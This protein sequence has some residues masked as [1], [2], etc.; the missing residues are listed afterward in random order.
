[1]AS[2]TGFLAKFQSVTFQLKGIALLVV[3]TLCFIGFKGLSGMNNAANSLEDLYSQGMQHTIRAGKI[4]DKL[5]DARSN[6]LLAQQHDPTSEVASLHDHPISVHFDEITTALASLHHIVD[7]EILVSD[8]SGEERALVN[9]MVDVLD[10]ITDEGFNPAIEYLKNNQFSDANLLLLKTINPEFKTLS[11]QAERFLALQT[12]EG[13]A[14]YNEAVDN[15]D[16][17]MWT[18]GGVIA[19]SVIVLFGLFAKIV[20]RMNNAITEIESTST[21]INKGDLTRRVNVSGDDEFA[22]IADSVNTLVANFQ[23]LVKD[24]QHSTGL[25]ANSASESAVVTNQTQRNV[26]DQQAQT[27]MIAA[28]IHEFTATVHE[29]ANNTSSAATASQEADNAASDGQKIVMRSIEM[30]EHLSRDLESTVDAM[31]Q[32]Q[33]H[34]EAIGSV[35]VTIQGISEQTNLLA[36]NAAIEAARAGEQGRGFAVVADEVRSLA[37]RTQSSTIEIQSTIQQLQEG[38]R[39]AMARMENGNTQAQETVQMAKDAGEAIKRILASVDEI[40]AMNTQIAT[41]AEQQSSVTEEINKNITTISSISDQTAAGAEQ[42]RIAADS[43]QK[44]SDEMKDK[45]QKY[46]I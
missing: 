10:V 42:S 1:M 19:L 41:A 25:L 14:N 40:N 16:R 24:T 6:L 18:V 33:K 38:S 12:E 30:I 35:V 36:L 28:A 2:D 26:L 20:F 45:I 23:S 15:A 22:H 11:Q 5:G 34:T 43:L 27:Q 3:V 32:L 31:N 46:V 29:V 8:I 37:Q 4:L 13:E 21:S 39:N 9:Q 44:L 17:F 7:N